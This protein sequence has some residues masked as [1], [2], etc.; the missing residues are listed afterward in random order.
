MH[1]L[2]NIV[3]GLLVFGLVVFVHEFGHFIAARW[4]GVPVSVFS[5]GFGPKLCSWHDRYGTRWQLSLLPLGGY[6]KLEGAGLE[7]NPLPPEEEAAAAAD[8]DSYQNQSLLTRSLVTVMGPAFNFLF[9]I[10]LFA[11][12]YSFYGRPEVKPD[13]AM[14]APES[15]AAQ[16]GLEKGDHLLALDGHRI[17][18]VPDFQAQIAAHPD[19]RV[20]LGLERDGH[21]LTLPVTLQSV[22]EG[23]HQIGRLGIGFA[24]SPAKPLPVWKAIPAGIVETWDMSCQVVQTIWQM[25]T[26]QR[27]PN[28]LAGTIGII[29]MSGQAAHYGVASLLFFIAML[30]ANL[31]LLNLFPGPSCRV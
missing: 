22:T 14:V 25:I 30:S 17:L 28:Q 16:A 19:A 13:V 15:A 29:N 11:V 31:G 7:E 3:V 23:T 5:I 10:L 26:G 1:A 8:P 21:V 2:F 4:R 12:L 20:E 18:S 9:A 27:N 24:V 6:V